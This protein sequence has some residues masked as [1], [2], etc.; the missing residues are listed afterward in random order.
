MDDPLQVLIISV[1]VFLITLVILPVL[2]QKRRPPGPWGF[3]VFGHLPRFG[4]KTTETFRKWRKTYGDIFRI[5][6]GSWDAVALNGYTTIKGALERPGDA[7]SGRP[8]FCS[9]QIS[10]E[11]HNNEESVEFGPFNVA[12]L[13]HRKLTASALRRF[14]NTHRSHQLENI[15]EEEIEA[16]MGKL[17]SLN[18]EP[19]D[20]REYVTRTAVSCIYQVLYGQ[21]QDVKDTENFRQFIKAM[22][23]FF[24]FVGSGNPMDV[25]PFL[26]YILRKKVVKF[27]QLTRLFDKIMYQQVSHH[28]QS[29]DEENIRDITDI[30]LLAYLPKQ[31]TDKAMDVTEDRLLYTLTDLIGAG[32]ATVSTTM[33][34]LILYMVAYPDAQRKVQSEL[35][36]VIGNSRK[37]YLTDRKQLHQT[38]AT[39]LEGMR[40][41]SI[42]PLSLPRSA[43]MD[44]EMNGYTI[45]KDTVVIVNLH[46][47]NHDE[48]L[49]ED[50][51]SFKP[52][53]H[54]DDDGEFMKRSPVVPFG[55][56]R[57]RCVGEF[58]AKDEVFLLFSNM[59]QRLTFIKPANEILDL[60]PI[61]TLVNSP[62]PFRV[63]IKER[64]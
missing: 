47:A 46:S 24:K 16:L 3:P 9:T 5:K 59:L 54:L 23:V 32:Y 40:L 31:V 2:K 17:K 61:E 35:D 45:D 15:I 13:K 56:G 48:S 14:T 55:L 63:V 7:F 49:W 44:T 62:K 60:Q 51:E 11:L 42:V 57:R 33:N 22:D 1:F 39:I 30:F 58:L 26:K 4:P 21:A 25:L 50:P 28:K 36:K 12:Y 18:E 6:L 53:R 19:K 38:Q 10:R 34:W 20:I 43:T 41:S 29:L 27:V 64:V 37:V 52:E 8:D